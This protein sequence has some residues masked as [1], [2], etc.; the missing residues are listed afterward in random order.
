MRGSWFCYLYSDMEL[1]RKLFAAVLWIVKFRFLLLPICCC[2]EIGI[3]SIWMAQKSAPVKNGV[4]DREFKK[5]TV[6]GWC[7]SSKGRKMF[8]PANVLPCNLQSHSTSAIPPHE[9]F[10]CLFL[11]FFKQLSV[12][13]LAKASSATHSIVVVLKIQIQFVVSF[14]Q[15]NT[16]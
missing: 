12:V 5:C 14:Y 6:S 4:E 13:N 15:I 10:L 1:E 2:L 8:L 16:V 3:K 9:D 7:H 11:S